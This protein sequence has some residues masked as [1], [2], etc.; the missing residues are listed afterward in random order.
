MP[1][2][3]QIAK[4]TLFILG[5]SGWQNPVNSLSI[6]RRSGYAL[7]TASAL[8]GLGATYLNYQISGLDNATH[9]KSPRPAII[10]DQ[11]EA[12]CY[13]INPKDGVIRPE[14]HSAAIHGDVDKVKFLIEKGCNINEKSKFGASP[15][16]IA[17]WSG[18]YEMVKLLLKDSRILIDQQ[19]DNG[20]GAIHYACQN[21]R[22]DIVNLL[23]DHKV[24]TQIKTNDNNSVLNL[25][26]WS[27][28][29]EL[30][31]TLLKRGGD[32]DLNSENSKHFTPLMSAFFNDNLD[33]FSHLIKA[34]ANPNH[35][36]NNKTH[37]IDQVLTCENSPKFLTQIIK[38][39]A[40]KDLEIK[41]TAAEYDFLKPR[42]ENLDRPNQE[43]QLDIGCQPLQVVSLIQKY[44]EQKNFG[45]KKAVT[46]AMT[47]I[48]SA[49]KSAK[50]DH[51]F[52]IFDAKIA[53]HTA[54]FMIKYDK[55]NI[56]QKLY[57]VD[58]MLPTHFYQE[59]DRDKF[60]VLHWELDQEKIKESGLDSTSFL[61]QEVIQKTF[62][63]PATSQNI[64]DTVQLISKISKT[65]P[66]GAIESR[67]QAG[68]NCT[69]EA[70]NILKQLML[71]EL[72][73]QLDQVNIKKI[74]Q[75]HIGALLESLEKY[76]H[77]QA[78]GSGGFV[79]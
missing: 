22:H 48:E 78:K 50:S 62:N 42:L 71:K 36:E 44:T 29:L 30:V 73:P 28:N 46:K 7:A 54:F 21:G 52:K 32:L 35:Q 53:G 27:N 8:S 37:L 9:S 72:N 11:S 12:A 56:A 26:A 39:K 13:N 38:K 57:Y 4:F 1:T 3:N 20:Y 6:N 74:N 10:S 69:M 5:G 60:G 61:L 34:G 16:T 77:S 19:D 40:I 33:I 51:G 68:E 70:I 75:N 55:N 41:R 18:N 79:R 49:M 25:A 2:K 76:K 15:I 47:E 43:I 65:Q 14:L 63:T 23:L 17:A 45:G 31:Q 59:A 24:N 64:K 58:S 67:G 66:L